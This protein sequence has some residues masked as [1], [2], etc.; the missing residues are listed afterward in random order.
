MTDSE[1]SII[2]SDEESVIIKKWPKTRYFKYINPNSGHASGRYRGRNPKQAASKIY[3]K[4]HPNTTSTTICIRESTR[5]SKKNFY[6]YKCSRDELI[7]PQQINIVDHQ[8]GHHKSITFKYIN[9]IKKT[10]LP[11]HLVNQKKP[12]EKQP[13]HA[14]PH[15]NLPD[16]SADDLDLKSPIIISI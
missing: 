9:C 6:A 16:S 10:K 12:V 8:T 4:L 15:I 14:K 2:D 7:V 3:S 13:S 1:N 5:G 11:N